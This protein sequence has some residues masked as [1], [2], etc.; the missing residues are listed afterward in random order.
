M[1]KCEC[2]N[3]LTDIEIA[4]CEQMAKDS[5]THIIYMCEDCWH[6]YCDHAITGG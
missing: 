1:R 4:T 3:W 2:G 6:N 5:E